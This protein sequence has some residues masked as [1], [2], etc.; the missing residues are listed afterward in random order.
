MCMLYPLR[1]GC[2]LSM[3]ELVY[4]AGW[5]LSLA[6]YKRSTIVPA[7]YIGGDADSE[8]RAR[9]FDAW[10]RATQLAALKRSQGTVEG[11]VGRPKLIC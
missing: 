8:V 10:D 9:L 5:R 2:G 3:Y 6:Y 7:W 11:N 1:N 4:V